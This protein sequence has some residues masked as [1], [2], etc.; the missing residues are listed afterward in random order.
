MKI[1]KEQSV[2]PK[3]QASLIRRRK[4]AWSRMRL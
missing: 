2:E 3:T 1:A 4:S